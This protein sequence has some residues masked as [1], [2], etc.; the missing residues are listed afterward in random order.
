MRK[1]GI[2]VVFLA[3]VLAAAAV[4]L[5]QRYVVP[6]GE[7]VEVP[8]FETVPVV[9]ATQDLTFGTT[10]AEEHMTVVEYPSESRPEQAYSDIDTLLGQITKVFLVAKE[11][12]V[13][14]KLSSIGGGLSIKIPPSLRASS[15]RVDPV[16][17]VSGFILPGDRVDVLVTVDRPSGRSDPMAQTVLQNVEV[18]AAGTAV[19]TEGNRTI[20]VQQITLLITPPDAEKLAL[21]QN[22]GKIQLT[23]R[24]PSDSDTVHTVAVSTDDILQRRAAPKPVWRPPAPKEEP[25]PEKKHTIIKGGEATE[26][27]AVMPEE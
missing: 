17:G 1:G 19:E 13:G 9:V 8:A 3:L 7:Q 15:V 2:F 10:L 5:F 25:P 4:V 18:L 23:L 12:I 20:D 14:P 22:E 21:A 24:N 11:P 6:G 27:K 26:G 16:S